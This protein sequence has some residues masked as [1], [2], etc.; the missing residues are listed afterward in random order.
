MANYFAICSSPECSRSATA[1]RFED[2]PATCPTCAALMLQ[3][4]W[5]CGAEIA[6]ET[7]LY[8]ADCGVPLKRELPRSSAVP[9]VLVCGNPE[10]DWGMAGA[11]ASAMQTRCPT[12]G[13]EVTAECWKCGTRIT[14][15]GQHYCA[16]C[17]VPLKRGWHASRP[18]QPAGGGATKL[19]LT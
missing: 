19:L 11:S 14:D 4:C 18:A 15:P 10:C 3:T 1:P 16:R 17:G 2:L 7:S 9:L 13:G 5:K 6:A 12:C 8:C